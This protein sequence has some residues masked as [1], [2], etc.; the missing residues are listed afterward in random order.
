M[1]AAVA[2][3]ASL[4]LQARRA[5]EVLFLKLGEGSHPGMWAAAYS[6]PRAVMM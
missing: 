1:K 3:F 2:S 6:T 5:D 4:G